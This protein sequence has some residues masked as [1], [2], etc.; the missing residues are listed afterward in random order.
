[1]DRLPKHMP[2]MD[3]LRGVAIIMVVFTHIG[4]GVNTALAIVQNTE[5]WPPSFQLPF[6][7]DK[8]LESAGNGVQ[9]FFVVSAFTLTIRACQTK[10][11][12]KSYAL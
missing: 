2:A 5:G 11:D 4:G 7:L 1:M 9:L 3:G 8:I 12:L 10:V 6:W